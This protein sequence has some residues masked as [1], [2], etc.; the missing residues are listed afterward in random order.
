[1]AN[2]EKTFA[3]RFDYAAF[4]NLENWQ[5]SDAYECLVDFGTDEET[6]HIVQALVVLVGNAQPDGLNGAMKILVET[7]LKY[8]FRAEEA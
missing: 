5:F 8:L 3:V 1:M 2:K 6:L 4:S 7:T